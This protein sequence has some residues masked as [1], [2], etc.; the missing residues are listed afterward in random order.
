[1]YINLYIRLEDV[2]DSTNAETEA[3][4]EQLEG[5]I[6]DLRDALRESADEITYMSQ[7]KK[8][9]DDLQRG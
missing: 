7:F 8:G 9:F 5:D 3:M 2:I 6:N 4:R 1:M